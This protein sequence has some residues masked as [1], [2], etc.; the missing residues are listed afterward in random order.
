MNIEIKKQYDFVDYKKSVVQALDAL[1]KTQQRKLAALGALRKAGAA[2][3]DGDEGTCAA[4][5][6]ASRELACV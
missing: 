5:R 3:P 4:L 1:I 6:E 2:P